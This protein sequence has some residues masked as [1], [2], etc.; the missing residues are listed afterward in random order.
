[1][2]TKEK[3]NP[4]HTVNILGVK[5]NAVNMEQTLETVDGWIERGESNYIC[6]TSVHGVMESQRNEKLRQIHNRAGLV[7]PDGMPLVWLSKHNGHKH[8]TR[9]YGPDLMLKLCEHSIVKG[10]RHF[11]YGGHPDIP[12]KLK[13]KLCELYPGFQVAGMY[14]PPFRRL[15]SEED[16]EIVD[17][18]NQAEPDIVWVGLGTPKQERWMAEHIDK[19][20]ASTLIGVGAAFDYISGRVKQAPIWMRNCGLEWFFRLMVEPKRLWKRYT[21][22]HP[23]FVCLVLAQ[24]AHLREKQ[25]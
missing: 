9:V 5:V 3:H 22:N 25:V 7:V 19:L 18:I 15:S 14:S 20:N 12:E 10:Y 1:M 2:S 13:A 24:L 8:V 16:R 21:R 23:L 11:I 17:K 6:V 4:L